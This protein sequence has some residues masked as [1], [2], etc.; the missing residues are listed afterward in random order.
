MDK[1]W[2]VYSGAASLGTPGPSGISYLVFGDAANIIGGGSKYIGL[3]TIEGAKKT[4]KMWAEKELRDRD[5]SSGLGLKYNEGTQLIF[6]DCMYDSQC[7]RQLLDLLARRAAAQLEAKEIEA[8]ADG[9]V[10]CTAEFRFKF[11]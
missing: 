4:A 11:K 2:Y 3:S 5:S 7:T 1:T 8:G 10:K 9:M 6:E